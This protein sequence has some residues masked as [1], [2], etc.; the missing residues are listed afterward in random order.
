MFTFLDIKTHE[1]I[2]CLE[3]QTEF[4]IHKDISIEDKSRIST[5]SKYLADETSNI[6][7]FIQYNF[8]SPEK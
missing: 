8:K 2:D 5:N 6:N 1:N 3:T 7:R 4:A